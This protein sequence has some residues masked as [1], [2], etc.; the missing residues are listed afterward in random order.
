MSRVGEQIDARQSPARERATVRLAGTAVLFGALIGLSGMGSAAVAVSLPSIAHDLDAHVG[1]GG[2]VIGSYAVA[3]AVSTGLFGRLSDTTGI[4]ASMCVGV[5]ICVVGTVLCVAATDI[6][7]LIAARALQG[8][9]AGAA[10]VLGLAAVRHLFTGRAR[11]RALAYITGVSIL[12]VGLGPTLGGVLSDTYGWRAAVSVPGPDRG[13][14]GSAL[15][16]NPGG[17][18]EPSAWTIVGAGLFAVTRPA[19]CCSLAAPPLAAPGLA[20]GALLVGLGAPLAVWW[21]RSHP[22]GFLP[23]AV[24]SHRSVLV[25]AAGQSASIG[26]WMGLLVVLPS[27]LAPQGWS[28]TAIGMALVPGAVVG[29]VAT[30]LAV[31]VLTRWGPQP[32]LLMSSTL[33]VVAVAVSLVGTRGG[34]DRRHGPGLRRVHP[35]PAGDGR[36]GRRR[37]APRS[38]TEPPSGRPR[39]SVSPRLASRPRSPPAGSRPSPR[40]ALLLWE[41]SH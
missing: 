13:G 19:S 5:L 24:L 28:A 9:G 38:T 22:D 39:S 27:V 3:L 23:R 25:A 8:L 2:W 15:A 11:V 40:R 16:T 32:V 35:G 14:A 31:R 21:V 33:A 29:V 17:T 20:A 7:V 26:A 4:R 6:R 18:G 1:L 36:R 41:W 34:A 10:Q 37:R 30:L 12:L